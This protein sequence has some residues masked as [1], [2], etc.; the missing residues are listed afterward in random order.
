[1]VGLAPCSLSA[2][3]SRA[4]P[5]QA[6]PSRARRSCRE[7]LELR[8]RVERVVRQGSSAERHRDLGPYG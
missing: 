4:S 7:L 2:L 3:G 6:P 8:V 1:M 5:R